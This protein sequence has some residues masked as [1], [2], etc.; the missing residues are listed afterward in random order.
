ME[1]ASEVHGPDGKAVKIW[2]PTDKWMSESAERRTVTNPWAF[3]VGVGAP[4]QTDYGTTI[5]TDIQPGEKVMVAEVGR[6]V[7]LQTADGEAGSIFVLPF[8][9]V[10]GKLRWKCAA[11]KWIST[12]EPKDQKCPACPSIVTPTMQ[13]QKIV[14]MTKRNRE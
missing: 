6:T 13:E 3:V 5:T 7:V 11:C 12:I 9:G 1:Y 14:E 8:E 4:R 2:R 10:L